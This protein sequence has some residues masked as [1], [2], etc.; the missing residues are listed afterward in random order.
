MNARLKLI[1]IVFL[2][3]FTV[4]SLYSIGAY[5]EED[6]YMHTCKE[7]TGVTITHEQAKEALKEYHLEQ[8]FKE[9]MKK[10]G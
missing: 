2:I 6:S 9:Y 8:E 5:M 10:G 7:T 3:M 1:G 4:N